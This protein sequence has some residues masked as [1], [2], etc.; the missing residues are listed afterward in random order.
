M[1]LGYPRNETV[2]G[3]EDER[4]RLGFQFELALQKHISG[5]L[6]FTNTIE[7]LA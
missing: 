4:S 5:S 7:W 2:L 3:L 6:G 1:T